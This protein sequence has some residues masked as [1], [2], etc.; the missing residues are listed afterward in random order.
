MK[1]YLVVGLDESQNRITSE[2]N[3]M[4]MAEI[5]KDAMSDSGYTDLEIEEE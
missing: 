3:T 1:K 4:E 5:I 2:A